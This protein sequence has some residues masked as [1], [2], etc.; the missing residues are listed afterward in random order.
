MWHFPEVIPGAEPALRLLK[1]KNK[2]IIFVSNKTTKPHI[3]VF[4]NLINAGFD[5]YQKELIMP[6]LAIISHLK[7]INFTKKIY[8]LGMTGLRVELEKAGFE[9][10]NSGPEIIPES[11][12]NFFDLA[13]EENHE[14]GA[15]ICDTDV[16]LNFLKLEKAATF[17]KQPETVFITTNGSKNIYSGPDRVL[18]GPGYF[19]EILERFTGRKALCLAKPHTEY[20]DFIMERHELGDPS[21]VLFIGDS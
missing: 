16:N 4:E 9:I 18:F 3:E 8:L 13:L 10:A 17:L 1:K 15:V 19:T 21:R 20:R 14:I 2:K 12:T 7:K 5:L 11:V 6:Q